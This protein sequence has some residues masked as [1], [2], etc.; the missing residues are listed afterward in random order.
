MATRRN[1]RERILE[2]AEERFA[3]QGFAAT[4]ISEIA[5]R[6]GISSPGIYKHF[7]NKLAIYEAVCEKL[8]AP[9]VEATSQLDT[10]SNFQEMSQQ[11]QAAHKRVRQLL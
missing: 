1:T 3:K 11:I 2:I 4:S 7:S 10:A 8:M 6:V 5:V 9:L